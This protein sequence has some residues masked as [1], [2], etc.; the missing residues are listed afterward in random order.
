MADKKA[1]FFVSSEYAMIAGSTNPTVPGER[2][3]F[4]ENNDSHKYLRERI[5]AGDPDYEHLSVVEV[6]LKAEAD[7][8]E[9]RDKQAEKARKAAAEANKQIAEEQAAASGPGEPLEDQPSATEGTDLPPQ[10]EEAVRLGEESGAGQRASTDADV[11]EDE[12]AKPRSRSGR[13]ARGK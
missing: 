1:T 11:V 5:E 13:S 9:E 4:D 3:P 2:V 6:D 7:Q 10:D 8:Q 12:S